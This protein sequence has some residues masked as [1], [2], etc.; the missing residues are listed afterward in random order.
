MRENQDRFTALV[1]AW[2]ADLYRFAF[3]LSR[4]RARAEDLVQETFLR[5]W[6]SL[7]SLREEQAA[8]S[9]LFTILR[10]EHVR[11]GPVTLPTLEIETALDEPA[12][13]GDAAQD[14]VIRRHLADL[15]DD[16]REP[17]LLQVLGGLSCDEIAVEL[18]ITRAAAMT[19]LFRARQK[20]RAALNG[21]TTNE[22]PE[23]HEHELP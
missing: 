8:K 4:D 6:R 19:R 18:G 10:R 17:L 1:N 23:V 16:Y 22:W 7:A 20:L 2:S 21:D 5:A 13:V 15:P 9:W 3:W 14:W 12:Q 11:R